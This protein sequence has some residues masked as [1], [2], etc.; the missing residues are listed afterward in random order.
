M[1]EREERKNR[2]LKN[3]HLNGNVYYNIL[4][5]SKKQKKNIIEHCKFPINYGVIK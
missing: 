2:M 5:L 4:S 3:R 1:L